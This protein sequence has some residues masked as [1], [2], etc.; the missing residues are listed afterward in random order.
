MSQQRKGLRVPLHTSLTCGSDPLVVGPQGLSLP[1]GWATIPGPLAPGH[2]PWPPWAG[3]LRLPCRRE[4]TEMPPNPCDARHEEDGEE[5]NGHK[6][7]SRSLRDTEHTRRGNRNEASLGTVT[8]K[9]ILPSTGQG[10]LKW[11]PTTKI[12][13]PCPVTSTGVPAIGP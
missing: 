9:Q 3:Q 2:L 12:R 11:P 6:D 7:M 5:D 13:S 1:E 8:N 10:V 4:Q